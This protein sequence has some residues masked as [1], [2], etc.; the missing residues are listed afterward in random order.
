[1]MFVEPNCANCYDNLFNEADKD[2][3]V[4]VEQSI[5]MALNRTDDFMTA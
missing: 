3:S 4:S 2:K 1:M 5:Y